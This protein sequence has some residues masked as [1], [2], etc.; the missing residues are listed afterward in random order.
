MVDPV[1][2]LPLQASIPDS[3]NETIAEVIAYLPTLIGA[4]V[5]LVVGYIV[6]RILGGLVTRVLSRIGITRYAQGTALE[7]ASRDDGIARAIGKIVSYYIYF[8]ALLAAANVLGI[9]QLTVLLADIAA[10][11]PV[12]LGAL[13]VLIVGFII[14]RVLGDIVAGIVGGFMIGRYLYGT[15]LE[16]FGDTEGEF[17]RLVGKLVTYYVYLLTLLAVADILQITALSTLLNTFAGYLPALVA[18][19]LVLVVGIWVAERV[20]ELVAESDDGRTTQ[21]AAVAVKILIYYIVVTITLDTVGLDVTVMTSLFTTFLVAFFGA[22]ALALALGIGLAVGLGGQDYV[23]ENVDRWV[24]R[25]KRE[26][27]EDEEGFSSP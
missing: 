7:S 12:V 25:G 3:I 27:S 14:G 4:L 24:R 9:S 6:G 11:L 5:I 22:L 17:G 20:G 10:Y 23:A 2:I 8:V 13:I 18:G 26:V 19:L 16:R 21:L 15:P 1:P